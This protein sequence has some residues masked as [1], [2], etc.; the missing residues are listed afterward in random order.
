V[1][2]IT[3][4]TSLHAVGTTAITHSS[5]VD[6]V[7]SPTTRFFLTSRFSTSAPVSE[8]LGMTCTTCSEPRLL[9]RSNE[10]EIVA[11]IQT[12]WPSVSHVTD[13]PTDMLFV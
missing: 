11:F 5:V 6:E 13:G 7:D 4:S 10:S 3:R 12:M 2:Y 1:K 8:E 9:G